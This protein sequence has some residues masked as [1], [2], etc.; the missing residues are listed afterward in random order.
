MWNGNPLK[1]DAASM[2]AFLEAMP[3]SRHDCQTLD[4]HPLK[5]KLTTRCHKLTKAVE[6]AQAGA[7]ELLLTVTGSVLHGPSVMKTGDNPNVD[8]SDMPRKF[9]EVFV[10]RPVEAAEGM[11]PKVSWLRALVS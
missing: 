1:A 2:T 7:P 10:L 5:G 6:G 11:Q 8:P 9:R 3:L 4:C